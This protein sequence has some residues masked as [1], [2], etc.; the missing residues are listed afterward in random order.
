VLP[1]DERFVETRLVGNIH[2]LSNKRK[3]DAERLGLRVL[4]AT[5]LANAVGKIDEGG[6]PCTPTGA[7]RSTGPIETPPDPETNSVL[8]TWPITRSNAL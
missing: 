8:L 7:S 2:L 3:V 6:T 5:F 1:N 4:T